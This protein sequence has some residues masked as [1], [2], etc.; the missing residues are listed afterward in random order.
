ML[1]RIAQIATVNATFNVCCI[2]VWF[3]DA[4]ND[5]SISLCDFEVIQHSQTLSNSYIFAYEK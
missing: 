4:I 3:L 5:A 2:T 1:G